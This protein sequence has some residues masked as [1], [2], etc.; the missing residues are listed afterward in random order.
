MSSPEAARCGA[1]TRAGRD[2]KGG[3]VATGRIRRADEW[4]V[5]VSLALRHAS[6]L[7]VDGSEAIDGPADE[8]T[9]SAAN[10]RFPY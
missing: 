6:A 9:T 2:P 5:F 4:I 8:A 7:A 3:G 10:V 1:S